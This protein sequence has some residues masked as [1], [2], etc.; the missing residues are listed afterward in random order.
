MELS[1]TKRTNICCF[2]VLIGLPIS[3]IGETTGFQT[4][5]NWHTARIYLP[6]AHS[7]T[8]G[9]PNITVA[10]L[11]NGV[12]FSHP[13]LNQAAWENINEIPM[14]GIDDDNNGYIDDIIGWD[15]VN[16]DPVPLPTPDGKDNNDNLLVDEL[17]WHGTFI[18]GLIS[19][20]D[21][22]N[23]FSGVAPSSK[24]MALRILDSDASFNESTWGE[25]AKAI[26][27]AVS[28]GADII[29]FSIWFSDNP[30]Q[31]FYDALKKTSAAEIPF[32]GVSG[33]ENGPV[34]Y[35][36]RISDILCVGAIS[37]KSIRAS[38]SNYGPE[39]DL[40]APG[41]EITSSTQDGKYLT[42]S[43]TSYAAPL[44]AGTMA[45]MKAVNA[46][47]QRADIEKILKETA[48]D[49][50]PL[51][52]DKEYGYGLLDTE[53]AVRI[54]A[55]LEPLQ[56][57]TEEVALPVIEF[58]VGVLLIQVLSVQ[59]VRQIMKKKLNQSGE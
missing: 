4:P 40:V 33:N 28:N 52:K 9:T 56:R 10:V 7:I 34:S 47:L 23:G 6:G 22:I 46:S 18:A 24:V 17:L 21:S 36:G 55:G 53:N 27:Y 12:N 39:L 32:I 44:V 48:I 8:L 1:K 35:P 42:N 51:G 11:D 37:K 14:N 16:D 41:D 57:N 30:P 2:I 49:L 25:M 3:L 5:D 38:F 43:G 26:D 15:F 58:F 59:R 45:L 29:S 31:V 50:G 54:A 20:K 19:G 13:A